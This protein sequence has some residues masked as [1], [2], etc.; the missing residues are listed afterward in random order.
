MGVVTNNAG[1]TSGNQRLGS[2]TVGINKTAVSQNP[3]PATSGYFNGDWNG[4]KLISIA[5][6]TGT[7]EN[8]FDDVGYYE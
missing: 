7:Y 1:T 4:S 8:R 5:S 2:V 3:L 6:I